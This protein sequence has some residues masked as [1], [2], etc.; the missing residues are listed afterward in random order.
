MKYNTEAKLIN[1]LAFKEYLS[2]VDGCW[3][4]KNIGGTLGTPFEGA[5]GVNNITFYKDGENQSAL[6]ND[7]LDL[8]LV[9]LKAAEVHGK[10][11]NAQ[12]LSDYW[13]TYITPHWDEYGICQQNLKLGLIPPLSGSF[14]NAYEASCGCFIRSELWA[15]LCPGHPE[16]AAKY[17]YEDA[18]VDHANEGVYSEI[19]TAVLQSA[20]FI[21]KDVNKLIEIALSYVPE[22]CAIA[23][24]TKM[25]LDG[26]KN[27]LDW[28]EVRKQ[29]YTKYPSTFGDYRGFE[30]REYEEWPKTSPYYNA[31]CNVGFTILGIIYGEGDFAKTIC[32]CVNCGE[33]A[34]CSAATAG[35]TMGILLGKENIPAEWLK[36][37]GTEIKT[38][39]IDNSLLWSIEVPKTTDELTK[40]VAKLMPKFLD[41]DFHFMD[42]DEMFIEYPDAIELPMRK[43]FLA[44]HDFVHFCQK[45]PQGIYLE[46]DS[47]TVTVTF[48]ENG[49][50]VKA[51]TPMDLKIETT[52]N[53]FRQQQM[54]EC[55][56]YLP[57]G[58]SSS[59]GNNFVINTY[60]NHHI[61]MALTSLTITPPETLNQQVYRGVLEITPM[62]KASSIYVPLRFVNNNTVL[63]ET[64]ERYDPQFGKNKN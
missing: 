60:Y 21:E 3:M 42:T 17:A 63:T 28:K 34:D 38:V 43:R 45:Q 7:D 47:F 46:N 62:G 11:V 53:R 29:I 50:V 33:D 58:F 64:E 19:F 30:D 25:V 23:D 12:I 56:L 4:G 31:I 51:A 27:G 39:S 16:L 13:V 35:A 5:R 61:A 40:R 55:H 22:D 32:L 59:L 1:K 14:M 24:V 41:N 49:P 10:D 48:P 52:T 20:A 54:L 57:E 2:K 44:V 36:P 9:W 26:K 6:P 18:I 37:I 8:Q 15:C